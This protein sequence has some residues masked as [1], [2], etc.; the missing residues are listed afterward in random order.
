MSQIM[1]YFTHLFSTEGLPPRW[2]CGVWT[3]FQGWFYILSDIGIW[4]AYFTI[5]VLLLT[6]IRR[7]KDVPFLRIFWLFAAFI[8]ACGMTH[9]MDALMFWWPAYR[10]S[11]VVYFFTAVISWVTVF[12]LISV[13]PKALALK[14]PVALESEIQDRIKAEEALRQSELKFR[15]LVDSVS[16]YAIFSLTPDGHVFTWNRGAEK[17]NGYHADEIIG[18]HF[19]CFYPEAVAASGFP[20]HE[21]E[22]ASQ[23]GRFEDEGWRIRKDGSRYWAN[24]IISAIKDEGKLLGFSK[25]TRDLTERKRAEENLQKMNADLEA[26]VEQRTESLQKSLKREQLVTLIVNSI[27]AE[28]DLDTMIQK[29]VTLLGQYSLADRCLFWLFDPDAGCYQVPIYEFHGSDSPDIAYIR[30]TQYKTLPIVTRSM[31]E[32][33]LGVFADMEQCTDLPEDECKAA[34]E[35]GLKSLISVPVLFHEQL[36]G[37]I[38][39]HAVLEKKEWDQE[40]INVVQQVADQVAVAVHQARLVSSLRESEARKAAIMDSAMDAVTMMDETGRV[41]EWN[42]GAERIF[43]FTRE[44]ILGQQLADFIV[45]ERLRAAH[46]KGLCRYLES[47]ESVLLNQL[48]EMPALRSDGSEFI[49]ELTVTRVHIA[50]PALFTGILRDITERKR[51]EAA[52]L[53]SEE[54]FRNM[55]NASPIMI[56]MLGPDLSVTYMNRTLQDYFGIERVEDALGTGWHGE[57]IHPADE[58]ELF[59]AISQA[60]SAHQSFSMECRALRPDGTYR[61]VV[62]TGVPRLGD[63]GTLQG[64]V[65]TTQDIHELK[66]AKE[67]LE[68]RVQERTAQLQAA[69]KELEAFSYSVSH[70]L[71]APLRTIDGF[72]QAILDM[73]EDKL[74]DRGQDYLNRIRQGSQ[75]MAKLIDDMLQLSRLTRGE[76]NMEEEVNLSDI[77]AGIATNLQNEEPD[78]HVTFD[79]EPGLRSRGDRRLLHAVMQNLVGNA[80]KYTSKHDT[81]HIEFGS[82]PLNNARIYYLKDDG[83]G[84]DMKYSDKLFG[85]FQ[86]LH[87]VDEFPGTG[88]GLATVARIIHRHGGEVWA[89]AEL[90]QG[91]T[92]YFTLQP[93]NQQEM[94]NAALLQQSYSLGRG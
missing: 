18:R 62:T 78:R 43:G 73:Y 23:E 84:F 14:S 37:R 19:S 92:F 10:L 28:S 3:P 88:V 55:A 17:L 32:K 87:G 71:R 5:P 1:Y 33:G 65:G 24:V 90:E 41:V 67:E 49:A 77:V 51:S 13:I 85:A 94:E 74:D 42:L 8:F 35:R 20:K 22:V 12:A 91:A 72:S 60:V 56:W 93:I 30:D 29:T 26:L 11:G 34:Q 79:I 69:N 54:R 27:R 75:Q 25:V 36:L 48:L 89:D 6:F 58:P 66:T 82:L 45:P 50:G 68:V 61:W 39:I 59:K 57:W 4:A 16:D 46:H 52:L 2:L 53:E 9:F 83:A 44:Q 38:Q 21:L 86:R 70:D 76:L 64:F 7:R 47:G 15:T 81:A 40:L 63:N 80:W 31:G